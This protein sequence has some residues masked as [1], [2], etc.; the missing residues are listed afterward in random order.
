[1]ITQ[2][3]CLKLEKIVGKESLFTAPEDLKCYSYDATNLSYMP[4]AV[5]VP[6]TPEEISAIVELA[7][8]ESFPVIPR[9]AGT[10]LT[11]GSLPVHG[12]LVLALTRL[13]HILE[14]D[15]ENL[16]ATVEPGVVT[17]D[18]QAEVERMG[19]F[20]PPD[21]SSLKTCT[22]GGNVAECAGGARA[23]KYGVT[24]D[25]VTGLEVVL[26]TGDLLHTG[27]R[28]KKGVVGYD[29]T[30]LFVGSEGTLGVITK[31]I[32]RLIPLP[33]SRRTIS[34]VFDR[35]DTAMNAVSR[36]ISAGIVPAALEFMDR[37]AI[38]C[39]ED[40]L[41]IGLPKKAGAFLLVEVDGR[42]VTV[43]CEAK[44]ICEF[45]R[46]LGA[47]DVQAARDEA[48]SL[49]LWKARRAVSPAVFKLKPHK[50]S[51]DIVVPRSRITQ[52]VSRAQEIGREENLIIICFGHA[53]DGNIHINIM[54]DRTDQTDPSRAEAAKEKIFRTVIEFG[55]TLSG[56]HGV[57]ITKAP[58]LGL[59]LG[60]AGIG[61]MKRIKKA[62]DPNSILNPGKIFP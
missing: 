13:N 40:Y 41:H 29:L 38:S 52:M 7:N 46:E 28:T 32:L 27:V 61:T 58:F 42:Q 12:G 36:I 14:I 30:R 56:E 48:H 10:G 25:Y 50:I 24:R 17:G 57:G 23:L 19:L 62:F 34:A 21:P 11:G 20:Y 37:F 22:L 26:P 18:F 33:E 35:M 39:V 59:E 44:E 60:D 5:A 45:F 31:I 2:T 9:G 43:D 3:A 49:V 6:R 54:F 55:G 8:K 15:R 1:M 51:E 53:G 4:D 16:T 47:R